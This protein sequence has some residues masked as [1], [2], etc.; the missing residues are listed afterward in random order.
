ML[1][2]WPI[3]GPEEGPASVRLSLPDFVSLS[4]Y[5]PLLFY[6]NIF[7][8]EL[9][10]LVNYLI[11]IQLI[12]TFFDNRFIVY[13]NILW[14]QI[15]KCQNLLLFLVLDYSNLNISVFCAVGT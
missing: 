4:V 1:T 15:L 6:E 5:F 10:R 2:E 3:Y 8:S 9:Q 7:Q 13:F 14:F 12:V 11:H